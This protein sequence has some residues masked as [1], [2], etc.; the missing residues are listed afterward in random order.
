MA[1]AVDPGIEAYASAIVAVARVEGALARVE[2]ELFRF[3]RTAEANSALRDR[4]IDERL[5][6]GVRI[7]V[8]EELLGGRA[9]PQTVAAAS[10]VVQSGR[11]RQLTEIADAVAALA[12]AERSQI[13][14]EVRSA[15]DLDEGQRDRLAT[16][17]QSTTG[18]QVSVRVIVDPQVVG[19][20]VVTLGDTVIDGSV[21][22]RLAQVRASLI[23]A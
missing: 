6:A 12:A 3:A 7:E 10:Y 14:A 8:V 13:V 17:L 21:A 5:S 15:I 11:A 23:G 4:L 20:L 2:D 18:K 22:R 19:G 9:H 1:V 16:A